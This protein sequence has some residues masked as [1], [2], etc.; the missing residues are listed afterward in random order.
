MDLKLNV[1]VIEAPISFGGFCYDHLP[2]KFFISDS[3][4][5]EKAELRPNLAKTD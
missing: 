2:I 4:I 3:F 1:T 5:R